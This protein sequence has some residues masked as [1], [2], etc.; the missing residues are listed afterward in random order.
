MG[1]YLVIW[2]ELE[3]VAELL[4]FIEDPRDLYWEI[5]WHH[6]EVLTRWLPKKGFKILPKLMDPNYTPGTVNDDADKLITTEQACYWGNPG[7][8]EDPI[9]VWKTKILELTQTRDELK[10]V[11]EEDVLDISFEEEVMKDVVKTH[12]DA[13]YPVTEQSLENSKEH[14]KDL[15]RILMRIANGIDQVKQG[16]EI[17]YVELEFYIPRG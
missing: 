9:P 12:P 15:A 16:G 4:K 13:H 17:P 1:E 3:G 14:L 5:G 11:I 6:R 7:G 10:R 2:G 8:R